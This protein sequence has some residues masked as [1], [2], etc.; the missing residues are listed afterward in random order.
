MQTIEDGIISRPRQIKSEMTLQPLHRRTFPKEEYLEKSFHHRIF[1]KEGYHVNTHKIKKMISE[2]L[3]ALLILGTKEL[4][5]DT[6]L[7]LRR[8]RHH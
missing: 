2:E 7:L 4:Q 6:M 8:R 3:P 5:Q 1:H